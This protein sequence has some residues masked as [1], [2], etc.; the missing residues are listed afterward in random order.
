MS[1]NIQNSPSTKSQ[2]VSSIYFYFVLFIFIFIG[3]FSG[4]A[5]IMSII[6]KEPT[7]TSTQSS[8]LF[9]LVP[10]TTTNGDLESYK[11]DCR[12]QLGIFS[13]TTSTDDQ[14]SDQDKQVDDCANAKLSAYQESQTKAEDDQKTIEKENKERN[15]TI[16]TTFL[17]GSLVVIILHLASFRAFR[18]FFAI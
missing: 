13:M 16:S 11:L 14:K 8:S 5:L 4:L 1:E 6:L 10:S 17:A 9:S 18:K 15:I 12:T 3:F 7:V 2:I